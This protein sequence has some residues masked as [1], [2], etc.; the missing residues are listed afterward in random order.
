[1]DD[2][3][4]LSVRVPRDSKRHIKQIAARKGMSVQELVG[5]LVD[6]LVE[7]ETRTAPSLADAVARL[8]DEKQGLRKLGVEHI[9][10]FGSVV[11]NQADR[12]SDI[13]LVVPF[14]QRISAKQ[15]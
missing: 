5:G 8:R 3:T 4:F 7:R 14:K 15:A 10:L 6:D 12:E 13:D 11:R 9:D 2:F 1:M